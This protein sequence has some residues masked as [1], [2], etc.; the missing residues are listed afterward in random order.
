MLIKD[1]GFKGVIIKLTSLKNIEVDNNKITVESGATLAMVS[2]VALKNSLKGMEFASGIPGTVGG[3][4]TMNAG[5]YGGEMKDILESVKVITPSG[6]IIEL[7]VDELE[8][9]YRS[10]KIQKDNYVLIEAVFSLEEGN[11]DEIRGLM[12]DLNSRRKD[13]Q[14][15][16]YPSAGSTFKRPPNYYAGKLIEDAGLKGF[17]VGGAMVSDKHAGFVINYDNAT[18]KDVITLIQKVQ[19]KVKEEYGIELEPEVKIIGEE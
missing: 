11:P 18:A 7:T 13:K 16:N 19:E 4:V 3:A 2:G 15:L 8:L 1:G 10:S 5:A 17:S 6:D 12:N 9:S 14:P